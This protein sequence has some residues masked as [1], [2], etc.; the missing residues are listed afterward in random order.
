MKI[1]CEGEETI[2]QAAAHST[3]CLLLGQALETTQSTVTPER[4][5]FPSITPTNCIRFLGSFSVLPSTYAV[6]LPRKQNRCSAKQ[7]FLPYRSHPQ[8][9]NGWQLALNFPTSPPFHYKLQSNSLT[10]QAIER[11]DQ[12]LTFPR[13]K[14][15][16]KGTVNAPR[17]AL[18]PA[19]RLKRA[20]N[21][22]SWVRE[23]SSEQMDH[24]EKIRPP[25]KRVT[26]PKAK[27]TAVVP[28]RVTARTVAPKIQKIK[29]PDK[30]DVREVTDDDSEDTEK[31]NTGTKEPTP[32]KKGE[33]VEGALPGD[34]SEYE[35]ES[36]DDESIPNT[37]NEPKEIALA[38]SNDKVQEVRQLF[39]APDESAASRKK[40]AMVMNLLWK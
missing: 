32:Q 40:V 9:I 12:F 6:S 4:N 27:S 2:G 3:V 38:N 7:K 33:A 16:G 37:S 23:A 13:W 30:E 34:N 36:S 1:R 8:R 21:Q 26:A 19:S 10:S 15:P 39:E 17:P 25:R 24:I 14:C 20:A 18:V 35:T 22:S 31:S 29:K 28:K 5:G 11:E